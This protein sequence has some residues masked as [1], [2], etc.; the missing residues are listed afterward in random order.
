MI[1][2]QGTVTMPSLPSKVLD[3]NLD[4]TRSR[5]LSLISVKIHKE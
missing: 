3:G 5:V 4:Q 2:V 1:R